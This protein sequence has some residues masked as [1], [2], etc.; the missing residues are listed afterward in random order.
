M[1]TIQALLYFLALPSLLA[2][3]ATPEKLLP[4]GVYYQETD[5]WV[6]QVTVRSSV[7]CDIEFGMKKHAAIFFIGEVPYEIGQDGVI[8]VFKTG[9]DL[10]PVISALR[11]IFGGE[12]KFPCTGRW[13]PLENRVEMDM[14]MNWKLSHANQPLNLRELVRP[15]APGYPILY[16]GP[17]FDF[18]APGKSEATH[19]VAEVQ[20]SKS[21]KSGALLAA[22]IPSIILG[23]VA[24]LICC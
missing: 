3:V 18:P 22:S 12:I 15:E 7:H 17:L 11:M 23:L 20:S 16:F 14:N 8:Q 24:A 13:F 1:K 9:S 10:H 4:S 6:M 5:S 21:A 2:T 19:V